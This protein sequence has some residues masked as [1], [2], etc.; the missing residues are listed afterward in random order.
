M[1]KLSDITDPK[2]HFYLLGGR[3]RWSTQSINTHRI[4]SCVHINISSWSRHFRSQRMW[5]HCT[6]GYYM[7]Y[8]STRGAFLCSDVA[9]TCQ[10]LQRLD[11]Y[12][13]VSANHRCYSNLV[14]NGTIDDVARNH[15]LIY[16]MSEQG[17]ATQIFILVASRHCLVWNLHHAKTGRFNP[18]SPLVALD[19]QAWRRGNHVAKA[20]FY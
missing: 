15:W 16:A 14:P 4:R 20:T 11:S 3:D 10:I 8:T 5:R 7:L 2:W 6:M 17:N 19:W 9:D 1:F 18:L 12:F 13:Y